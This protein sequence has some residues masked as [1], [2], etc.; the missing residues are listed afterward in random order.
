MK[1][2]LL[3]FLF[4]S[5]YT[6]A[7]NTVQT[8]S[9]ST[10]TD[11]IYRSTEVDSKPQLN[12]GMYKLSLFISENFKFSE[13]VKNK[14]IT[15]FSSFVIEPDGTMSDIKAFH[16]LVKEYIPS[17]VTKI[18]TENEKINEADEIETMKAE[19]I[20]VL[21]LFNEKWI[22]AQINGKPV[23]CLYN[24]PINFTIE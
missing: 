12:E 19:T 20:R 21:K 23:R 4:L 14:K 8:Q 1:N 16:I 3:L 17:D 6:S 13:A 22:S 24:Y 5:I 7:Q 2:L 10:N 11:K 9:N 18:Q 15:V